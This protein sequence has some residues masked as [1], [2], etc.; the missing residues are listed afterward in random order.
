[1]NPKF[2]K[3]LFLFFIPMILIISSGLSNASGTKGSSVSGTAH[4]VFSALLYD[5]DADYDADGEWIELYNPG[6]AA[7][8][9]GD[10]I[11]MDNARTFTIPSGTVIGARSYL[12]IANNQSEFSQKYGCLPG[13]SGLTLGLNNVGD[14]L[15]LKNSS[16]TVIDRVAWGN[17]GINISGWGSSSL[18]YAD[19]GKSIAR[20]NVN[21]DTDTYA[22]W[23][24]N[25]NPNP[26][27]LPNILL[28]RTQLNF[29]ASAGVE[30]GTQT[31][32][33]GYSGEGTPDWSVSTSAN[34]I[35]YSPSSGTSPGEVSVS[36]N[37]TGLS[38]GSYTGTIT[39]S[40]PNAINSPQTLT[41]DLQV[42]K[43]GFT[44]A[45]FG[46][47]ATPIHGAAVRSSIPVTGWVLDD[48]E[49]V[50]VKIYNGSDYVGDAVFVEGARP[51]VE[52][53]YPGYPK[54]YRAGWGY[55]ML[56]Y[57]LPNGG[58]GTYTINAIAA[59]AEGNQVTLGSKVIN[60]DNVNAVKPFGAIDT[61]TQ[62][63]TVS[64]SS[65]INWGW[66]LTPQPNCIPIDGSTI[67]V[68]VDGVNLGHPTYNIYR[69]DIALMFPYYCN[70]NG[71]AGYFY[72]DTT[73]Y[74]NGVHTIQWV[75]TDSGGN[76]DGIGSRYFSI[77]NTGSNARLKTRGQG[78]LPPCVSPAPLPHEH[79]RREEPVKIIKGYSNHG[80]RQKIYPDENGIIVVEIKELERVEIHLQGKHSWQPVPTRANYRGYMKVND[81]LRS[82]PVGST[83]DIERG[84][85][86]WQP[87][88]GFLG[89]YPLV[90]MEKH[91]GQWVKRNIIVRIVP[92][93]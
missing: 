55:M 73:V 36:V 51:D 10:W 75:V 79:V 91:S 22:D 64:G 20:S 80:P 70:S 11:I 48:I 74:E 15:T 4:V 54:N 38:T 40:D 87:G 32:A 63:G 68:Y 21:Q 41:V 83:L 8:D 14:Y 19:K 49:V 47:F 13:V 53:A 56:T 25:Q 12:V 24:N 23:L 5:S 86:Y 43:P 58:N 71:A 61:P 69:S 16:G 34:W 45:P 93:F 59:D 57:F 46:D 66:A 9:T 1:M 60:I 2:F 39:V 37:S 89:E 18:P 29:G 65:Y 82:L 31:F 85:F 90:F 50:S 72:L 92:G 77:Q 27:N 52:L 76:T 17:G 26:C 84:I 7:V 78:G 6:S 67:K 88:V 30:T 42:Y 28:N 35:S 33:I 81:R 44:S 3:H 62:G